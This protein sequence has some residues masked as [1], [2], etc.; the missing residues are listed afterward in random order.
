MIQYVALLPCGGRVGLVLDP[1]PLLP[2]A[3][4]AAWMADGFGCRSVADVRRAA[5]RLRAVSVWEVVYRPAR[6]SKVGA[7]RRYPEVLYCRPVAA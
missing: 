2:A 6:E 3:H 5:R 4:V 7:H 1:A